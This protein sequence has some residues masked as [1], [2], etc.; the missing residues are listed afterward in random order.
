MISLIESSVSND[1]SLDTIEQKLREVSNSHFIDENNLR[2]T[3]LKGWESAVD[4]AF[5]DG[6]LTEEEESS[7]KK[8][9][10]HFSL[11]QHDFR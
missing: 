11:T 7:L 1:I 8:L 4:R 5:D 2:S 6:I 10:E 9:A 3:L